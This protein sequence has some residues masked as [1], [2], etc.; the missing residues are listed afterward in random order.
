MLIAVILLLLLLL[1]RIGCIA[2]TAAETA[3]TTAAAAAAAAGRGAFSA[4]SSHDRLLLDSGSSSTR[5]GVLVGEQ[6]VPAP[7]SLLA[8]QLNNSDFFFA[9]SNCSGIS[10]EEVENNILPLGKGVANILTSTKRAAW[11][12]ETITSLVV[13]YCEEELQSAHSRYVARDNATAAK[14]EYGIC[15]QA[16]D[17]DQDLYAAGLLCERN[18]NCY[19]EEPEESQAR[20]RR[21]TDDAYAD[22]ESAAREYMQGLVLRYGTLGFLLAIAVFVG[23]VKFAVSR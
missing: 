6:E 23:S 7:S 5:R 17:G 20:S 3:A 12:E 8:L 15:V 4:T 10:V 21:Y 13:E 9:N 18:A 2:I 1:L 14:N 11:Y 22:D 16:A 19:W